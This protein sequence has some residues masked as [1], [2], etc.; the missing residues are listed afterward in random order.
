MLRHFPLGSPDLAFTAVRLLERGGEPRRALDTALALLQRAPRDLPRLLLPAE[1]RQL[2]QPYPFRAT[3]ETEAR[4][5]AID[6]HLLAAV[7]REESG[8]DPRAR[9]TAAAHGLA[10]FVLPTARL[11]AGQIGYPPPS[12]ADLERPAVAIA[13]GAAYLAQLQRALHGA[14]QAVAAYNAGEPQA[15]LWRAYCIGRDDDE[16]YTKVA[17]QETRSYVADVM[18]SRDQYDELY[19]R[20][21]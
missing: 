2:L 9:S 10:Q 1:L 4:R 3:I 8:F 6:P 17:F 5:W 15:A 7:L 19:R 13:L 12:V 21:R 16:Y 18:A 11:L 14:V 20:E